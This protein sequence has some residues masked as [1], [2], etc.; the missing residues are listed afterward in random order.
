MAAAAEVEVTAVAA[1][2]MTGAAK[3]AEAA[4]AARPVYF[5]ARDLIADT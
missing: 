3:V 2:E 4:A 1:A 5:I